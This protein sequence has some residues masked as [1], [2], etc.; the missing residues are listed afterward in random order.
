MLSDIIAA[1]PLDQ[2]VSFSFVSV[3]CLA[4]LGTIHYYFRSPRRHTK[5]PPGPRGHPFIGNLIEIVKARKF[6]LLFHEWIR[7][8]GGLVMFSVLGARTLVIGD[9]QIAVDLLEKRSAIYS[10]RPPLVLFTELGGW[11]RAMPLLRYGPM[12]RKHRKITQAYLNPRIVQ[13]YASLHIELAGRLLSSLTAD[14]E[15]FREH[16]LLY[17]SATV[18][19]LAYD[20]DVASPESR[21]LIEAS[22]EAIRKSSLAAVNG[23]IVNFIPSTKWIYKLYPEWAPFSGFKKDLV[24]L[25]KQ[26]ESSKWIPYNITK[27]RIRDGSAGPSLVHDVIKDSGGLGGISKEDEEDLCG[28]AGVLYGAGQ[29]TTMA[30][31][32]AFVLAMVISPDVQ[33]KAQEEIDATIPSGRLPT[34]DDRPDLPYLE[35]MLKELFRWTVPIARGVPHAVMEDDVYNGYFIPKDTVVIASALDM[36]NACPRPDEFLPHRFTDGTDLGSVPADPGD[37]VF[38]FGRRRCPGS[39]IASNSVWAAMAQ[40]LASFDFLPELV[41]G[42]ERPPLVEFEEA[43]ARYP[44]PFKC[45]ILPRKRQ[46]SVALS[47]SSHQY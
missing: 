9:Y 19:R 28:I 34:L 37:I 41:D 31:L 35:A 22:E 26:V 6:P 29:E 45:R 17:S 47:T 7:T 18:F 11:G 44:V 30:T 8:Y 1:F 46:Q 27:D 25:R 3:S 12:L 2:T 38:G 13:G 40:M 21:Y 32:S 23:A 39:Y 24:A 14:P 4:L 36:C 42:K 33:R 10:D 20:L 43:S 15:K 16:I 5:F